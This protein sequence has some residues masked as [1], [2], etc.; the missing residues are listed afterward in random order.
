MKRLIVGL[1]VFRNYGVE[2]D[3]VIEQYKQKKSELLAEGYT[4][5]DF[6]AFGAD[7]DPKLAEMKNLEAVISPS[8]YDNPRAGYFRALEGHAP[9]F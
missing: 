3:D 6:W 8:T 7:K 5:Q 2:L 9:L 4:E 1:V